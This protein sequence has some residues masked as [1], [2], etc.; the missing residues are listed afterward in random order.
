ML[1]ILIL[2]A[3]VI[4][5]V[6]LFVGMGIKK[7]AN[8]AVQKELEE[9]KRQLSYYQDTVNQHVFKTQQIMENINQ[10]F[11]ELQQHSKD[12]SV[13]LNAVNPPPRQAKPLETDNKENKTEVPKDYAIGND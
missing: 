4:F 6:G 11:E 9:T 1:V 5:I 13:K 8:S 2:I 3:I 10:Q 7:G 12:Y